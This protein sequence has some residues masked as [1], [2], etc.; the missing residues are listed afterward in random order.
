[1]LRREEAS[2]RE[3]FTLSIMGRLASGKVTMRLLHVT[4][5]NKRWQVPKLI[6][7]SRAAPWQ[8]CLFC[9]LSTVLFL[10]IFKTATSHYTPSPAS[11]S[12]QKLSG[13]ASLHLSIFLLLLYQIILTSALPL[14]LGLNLKTPSLAC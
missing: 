14:A 3:Q 9:N 7:G 12:L 2:V 13:Q 4:Y 11:R 10:L 8:L 5:Y 1:M 6:L